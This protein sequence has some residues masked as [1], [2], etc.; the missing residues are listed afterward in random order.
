[1]FA[2]PTGIVV[3]NSEIQ[4]V[5]WQLANNALCLQPKLFIGSYSSVGRI[6]FIHKIYSAK[7]SIPYLF[8][9]C[10]LCLI[11]SRCFPLVSSA[12]D[13]G[14]NLFLTSTAI[15]SQTPYT[16]CALFVP[17]LASRFPPWR[18]VTELRAVFRS[19]LDRNSYAAASTFRLLI[20]LS[21]L[22][23]YWTS[24]QPSPFSRQRICPFRAA[25]VFMPFFVGPS[26]WYRI[27]K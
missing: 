1:M 21:F 2:A 16:P 11:C 8:R 19:E 23:H 17:V 27:T 3:S 14:G 20:D 18:R 4:A 15:K 26:P 24:P 7:S 9:C 22:C 13:A 6:G 12:F 5:S 25:A 10:S